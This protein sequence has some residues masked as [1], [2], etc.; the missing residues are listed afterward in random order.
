MFDFSRENK[1][2]LA[3]WWRNIDKTILSLILLL[4]FLGLFFSFSST[5]S[6]IGEKLNKESYF[7]FIKHLIFVV[8]A[9]VIIFSISIQKRSIVKS[10]FLYFFL[11]FFFL[12]LL[13][14]FLGVEVKGA[15]RWLDLPFLPRFQPVEI[16]KPLFILM[17]VQIITSELIHNLYKKYFYT[18][19]LLFAVLC[20]LIMQ[21]D[22][23]QSVLILSSW[24]ITIFASGINFIIIGIFFIFCF[25]ILVSILLFFPDKFGYIFFRLK[26]FIDPTKGGDYQSEKALQ[27]IK[28]G[29]FTGRGL[30][31]GI[32]KD[33][34]PEAHT[35][36]MFAIIAEEFGVILILFLMIIFLFFSY[37]VLHKLINEK[38]EYIRLVLFG[39]VSLLLIQT[40]IHIGVN[41]RLLPTTGITLPFLS[42]GG[43][44]I[45]GNAIT[46]GLI[47]NLTKKISLN[48]NNL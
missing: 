48:Q 46:A 30:G 20:L 10:H 41:I 7:F 12:L 28:S 27:A 29:G 33:T 21:P 18:L 4:F 42:Y 31:E 24:L 5:S 26:S 44:S 17:L 47:L 36:Y 43:S 22:L 23:G 37:K 35:D 16:L 6:V 32:L 19:L 8:A 3:S 9:I 38:D 40:F 2:L 45:I 39:L 14:P 15:K 1:S 34:V 25:L 11:I 13:V